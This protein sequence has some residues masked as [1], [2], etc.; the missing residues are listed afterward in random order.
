MSTEK[1]LPIGLGATRTYLV[2][3]KGGYLLIDGGYR[4]WKRW[5]FTCLKRAGVQPQQ[6]RL[7]VITHVHS[8]HVGTL[9][10]VKTRCGCAVAVHN[11]EA[12]LLSSAKVVIPPGTNRLGRLVKKITDR[13]PG[14]TSRLCAFGPVAADIRITGEVS[15]EELGFEAR[16]IPT[17]GHTTGSV[18]VLTAAGNAFVGDIA[19][20]MPLLGTQ[21]YASP[22][23]YSPD[24]MATSLWHLTQQG[25]RRIYPAHGRPFD[26]RQLKL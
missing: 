13:F 25:A 22:F 17:P 19:V 21:R 18:S 26:A 10:A 1:V 14:A 4:V 8:D 12:R 24:E 9:A 11:R 2:S 3:G 15:L 5:F 23:G 16:I 6:I 7:A 20:N